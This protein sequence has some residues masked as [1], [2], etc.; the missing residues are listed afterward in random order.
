MLKISNVALLHSNWHLSILRC[1]SIPG[2]HLLS[3]SLERNWSH[4]DY[5]IRPSRL[6]ARL[7]VI[8]ARCRSMGMSVCRSMVTVLIEN[9]IVY[10]SCISHAATHS[11][12]WSMNRY[13]H[14]VGS[15]HHQACRWMIEAYLRMMQVESSIDVQVWASIDGRVWS[16]IVFNAPAPTACCFWIM[17]MS[18]FISYVCM[19]NQLIMSLNV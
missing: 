2:R 3:E 1:L 14:G 6:P 12:V 18:C 7:V 11:C 4:Q 19:V 15:R 8:D 13:R 5:P 10:E 16:S 17:A 9:L